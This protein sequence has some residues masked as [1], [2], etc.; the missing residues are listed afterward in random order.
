MSIP[1]VYS[2]VCADLWHLHINA[3]H[4]TSKKFKSSESENRF[5]TK[6]V[7][8]LIFCASKAL[9]RKGFQK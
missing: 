7:L 8:K 5:N 9:R 4:K 2:A 3:N 1:K 6:A